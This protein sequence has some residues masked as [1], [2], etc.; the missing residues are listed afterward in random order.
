MKV[1]EQINQIYLNIV[2]L[3]SEIED[4]KEFEEYMD[5]FA[6]DDSVPIKNDLIINWNNLEQHPTVKF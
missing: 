4:Q 5:F 2:K 3:L 6:S 1:K